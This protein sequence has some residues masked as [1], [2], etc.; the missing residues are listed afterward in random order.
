[1]R[2]VFFDIDCLRPDHLGCYGYN[3]PTSPNIDTVARQGVRFDRYY[4]ADSPCLPSRMNWSS[5]RLGIRN[6]VVS[7]FGAGAQFRIRT[8]NYV[9]PQEDNDMLMRRLRR[10]GVHPVSFS[11]FADRHNMFWFECGWAEFHT[12][13]LKGGGEV[14]PEIHEPLMRWLKNNAR[15]EDYLLHINYWDAHRVYKMEASWADRFKDYPV[16]QPW[17]D[18]DAIKQ[19]QLIKGPFTAQA[20]FRDGKSTVPLMPDSISSRKDFEHLING[21]DAAIAYVDHHI[22]IVLNELADQGVLDDSAIIITSDHGDSFGEHGIYSDHVNADECI[23]HIPLVIKWP[24]VTKPG[25]TCDSMLYNID[26][27]PTL[28]ELYGAEIPSDWDGV[29]FAPQ[30]RGE[31]GI[32]RDRLVW[33]HALYTVQRAVRTRTHLLIHTYDDMGYSRKEVELYDM[34]DD[35]YQSRDIARERQDVACELDA[36]VT[37]Q[38]L[39][40]QK[41]KPNWLG[42]PFDVVLAERKAQKG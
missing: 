37:N 28:C 39:E 25:S 29:S 38:W 36:Y 13:N 11:N 20:Q 35:P 34:V 30:I 1:M 15:R 22:G 14:A 6:G 23:H 27:S 2:T 32:E 5:G 10:A 3:R 31:T 24:G 26:L 18:E 16:A 9:G 19:H 21:Y 17:P 8:R 41:S 40:E 33:G 12:P 42:D 7:N 4:C